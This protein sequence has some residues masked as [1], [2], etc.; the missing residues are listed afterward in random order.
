ME[1]LIEATANKHSDLNNCSESVDS[2][3]AF[4][5]EL[6]LTVLF[7]FIK[8]F[9]GDR[10]EL[11]TFIQNANSAFTLAVQHQKPPLLLY[12]VSQLSTSV[13]NEVELSEVHSWH[14]LKTK[15]KL[16]YSHTKHLAQA[17]EELETIRQLASESITDY[18]KR[19]ERAKNNCFQSESINSTSSIELPGI[20]RAIQQTALRRFIIHCKPEVSQMLRA[21]DINSLNEAYGLALQEEK[22]INYTKNGNNAGSSRIFCSYCKKDNHSSSQCR[23]K[24]R[25]FQS[26]TQN[27]YGNYRPRSTNNYSG[28]QNGYQKPPFQNRQSNAYGNHQNHSSP[29]LNN[30]RS[31][32]NNPTRRF[33][34][35]R[36]TYHSY[37]GPRVNHINTEDLNCQA[38]AMNATSGDADLKKAF[39]TLQITKN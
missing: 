21:R 26:N 23:Q 9:N 39:Q 37:N 34:D 27:S 22:I 35:T 36:P 2:D 18:F 24:N 29:P 4:N 10:S 13:V 33:D 30:Y 1:G 5:E 12:I 19:V 3:S 11:T 6:P 7:K 20:K 31:S 17:H 8:P 38:P 25:K 15:L 28:Y 32:G 16:Y 14:D